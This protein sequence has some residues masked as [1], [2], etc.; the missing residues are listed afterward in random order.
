[1]VKTKPGEAKRIM[2]LF[3][4]DSIEYVLKRDTYIVPVNITYYP[5]RAMAN[6]LSKLA[7]YLL[8]EIEERLLEEIMIEGTML[9]SGVDVDIRF[10]EPLKINRFMEHPKI[11]QDISAKIKINFDDDLPSKSIMQK[12]AGEGIL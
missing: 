12:A 2:D 11:Q 3:G 10:G 5:V 9:F 6:I 1:M 7:G 4:I 8:E